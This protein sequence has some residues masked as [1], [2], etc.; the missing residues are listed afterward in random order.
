[1]GRFHH[2]TLIFWNVTLTFSSI[3]AQNVT[4][5]N[6]SLPFCS[7][8]FDSTDSF[9]VSYGYGIKTCKWAEITC[10]EEVCMIDEVQQHC[11]RL[12]GVECLTDSGAV[13]R[14][15]VVPSKESSGQVNRQR[16]QIILWS[17]AMTAFVATV[18]I[19]LKRKQIKTVVVKDEVSQDGYVKKRVLTSKEI[20]NVWNSK[21]RENAEMD[22]DSVYSV[23]V[24]VSSHDGYSNEM[25]DKV[26]IEE[27]ST[28]AG[29]QEIVLVSTQRNVLVSTQRNISLNDESISLNGFSSD[30]DD[31]ERIDEER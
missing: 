28:G 13:S 19:L 1:M 2:F 25:V 10:T 24:S 27:S 12:C 5:T 14:A 4:D 9:E 8:L 6:V 26:D 29:E 18:A 31:E 7:D 3:A 30:S 11:P 23:C 21:K 16:T 22:K 15:Q 17:L 20:L